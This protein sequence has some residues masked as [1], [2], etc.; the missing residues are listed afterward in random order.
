M[1]SLQ[2]HKAGV[3][4]QCVAGSVDLNMKIDFSTGARLGQKTQGHDWRDRQGY[5]ISKTRPELDK[6]QHFKL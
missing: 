1:F 5:K 2:S 3:V 4:C 6:K